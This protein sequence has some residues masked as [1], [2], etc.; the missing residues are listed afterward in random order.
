[1]REA[2]ASESPGESKSEEAKKSDEELAPLEALKFPEECVTAP[3]SWDTEYFQKR[4][5]AHRRLAFNI[6]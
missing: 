4:W 6:K 2:A 3:P 5:K 1:M